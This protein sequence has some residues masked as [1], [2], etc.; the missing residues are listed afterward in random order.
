MENINLGQLL[1]EK[2]LYFDK[3]LL[4][5]MNS[6][7]FAPITRSQSMIF[8]SIDEGNFTT[9]AI[10]LHLGISRQA[11]HKTVIELENREFLSL[12]INPERR[13]SKNI[14]LSNFGQECMAFA[15]ESFKEMQ[16]NLS[17]KIGNKNYQILREILHSDWT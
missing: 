10:A 8:A 7:K 13:S 16:M 9:S 3:T 15:E 12:V 4:I 17:E 6:S 2:F 5:R 14:I 11:V 1:L